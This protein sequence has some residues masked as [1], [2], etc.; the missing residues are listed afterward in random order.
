ML[1]SKLE[2]F[3]SFGI[4]LLFLIEF[5][6]QDKVE[7]FFCKA[8]VGVTI[9]NCYLWRSLKNLSRLVSTSKN[10]GQHFGLDRIMFRFLSKDIWPF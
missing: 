9:L 3:E 8:C 2:Y 10:S 4:R 5:G 6:V 7:V 1:G